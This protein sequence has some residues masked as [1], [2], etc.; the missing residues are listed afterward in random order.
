MWVTW[1]T[2][3]ATGRTVWLVWIGENFL[4][5]SSLPS[6]DSRAS[7][8][9]FLCRAQAPAPV[10]RGLSGRRLPGKR[11]FTSTCTTVLLLSV[12]ATDITVVYPIGTGP[13][14]RASERPACFAVNSSVFTG[15]GAGTANELKD[16]QRAKWLMCPLPALPRAFIGA[17][18]LLVTGADSL[19]LPHSPA[20]GKNGSRET[21]RLCHAV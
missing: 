6:M 11:I 4:R 12:A 17:A 16:R 19:H 1:R 8:L 7:V 9:G 21:V 3:A 5:E 10:Q 2:A 18:A 15:D 13:Q 20:S 14:G